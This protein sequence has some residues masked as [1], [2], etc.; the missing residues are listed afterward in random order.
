M[1]TFVMAARLATLMALFFTGSCTIAPL[2][3]YIGPDLP[4]GE[5]A[6][7][8]NGV[9]VDIEKYDDIRLSSSR[10]RVTVL[11]GSHSIEAVFRNQMYGDMVLYSRYT[12]IVTF[13]AEAGHTYVVYAHMTGLHGWQ[14]RV[15]DKKTGDQIAHSETLPVI[16]E[17][18]SITF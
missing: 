16:R 10:N 5:T 14:A 7:I 8:E 9:Y 2:K 15:I 1:K 13:T 18:I 6:V 11:P 17:W 3:G 4:P 12:A